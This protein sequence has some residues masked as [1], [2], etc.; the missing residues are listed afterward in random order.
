MK[1]SA[2][3]PIR[4]TTMSVALWLAWPPEAVQA[5]A[6]QREGARFECQHLVLGKLFNV[7]YPA[8]TYQD[9]ASTSAGVEAWFRVVMPRRHEEHYLS[10]DIQN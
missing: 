6:C 8:W 2:R 7:E 9:V 10:S 1:T 3:T 5:F 4:L